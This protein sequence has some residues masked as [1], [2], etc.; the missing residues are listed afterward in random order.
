MLSFLYNVT[1]H[2]ETECSL[3]LHFFQGKI[4]IL[5]EFV[6]FPNLCNCYS[7]RKNIIV[8]PFSRCLCL[9]VRYELC[10]CAYLLHMNCDLLLP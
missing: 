9:F 8:C 6:P 7:Q 5:L 2:I 1:S 4:S 3:E 10:V